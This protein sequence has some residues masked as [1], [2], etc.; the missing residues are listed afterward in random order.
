MSDDKPPG[1]QGLSWLER[2][3]QTLLGEPRDRPQLLALLR[4]AK[5]RGLLDADTLSM[6]E[7]ALKVSDM[8]ARDIMIPRGQA[9]MIER[10]ASPE[11]ILQTM[12][13]SAHSRF[14]VVGDNRDEV[15]GILLAKDI[16]PQ[17]I[18]P[19]RNHVNI[20]E[21]LR[22]PSFIPESKRLDVL[23]RE[24]RSSRN[25]MA[26]VVDEY[27][28]VSGLI[29][30]ED[31]LEQI[32]GEIDDEHDVDED[33]PAIIRETD[34]SFLV[35]ASVSIEDFNAYF[36]TGYVGDEVSTVGGLLVQ[37]FGHVPEPGESLLLEPL[38]F[39][40]QDV[41]G[42]RLGTVYVSWLTD[43]ERARQDASNGS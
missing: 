1:A 11:A 41:S 38:Q 37:H 43:S 9:V 21:L 13:E 18:D 35:Q 17:L 32:V 29:T 39:E 2:L 8:Q 15:L 24:F 10:N 25:H 28:S 19:K 26:V 22:P 33:N 36:G 14:P 42:G 4:D 27:G 12:I 7:G 5:T 23:L 40:V 30:I 20:A 31:V 6:L 34:D 3:G 16:L